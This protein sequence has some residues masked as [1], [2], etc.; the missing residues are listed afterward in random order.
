MARDVEFNY[1]ASDKTGPAADSVSKRAK[2][3]QDKIDKENDKAF[4]KFTK[5]ADAA[6]AAGGKLGLK[7]SEGLA[8]ALSEVGAMGPA[9]AGAV[10]GALPVIGASLA[11]AV[12][13]GSAGVGII[14]GALLASRDPRVKKAGADL[15]QRLLGQATQKA[16]VFVDPLLKGIDR[17]D[18]AFAKSGNDL[19][20]IFG[21][22]AKY[23]DP[24]VQGFTHLGGKVTHLVADLSEVAGPVINEFSTGIGNLGDA[25][26]E[27]LGSLKD[28]GVEAAMVVRQGFDV[29]NGSI[30][31]VGATINGLTEA[32][33]VLVKYGAFGRDAAVQY[34]VM[35]QAAAG[36]EAETSKVA[37]TMTKTEQVGGALG[38]AIRGVSEQVN[39][40]SS[41]NRTLYGSEVAVADALAN[42]T[43]KIQ[44]NGRGL[45]LNTEAGRENRGA[46]SSVAQ[47]LAN[48]YQ[49]YL[50]VNGAGAGAERVAYKA[51][52]SFTAL[53][54]QAGY[55]AG[56]AENLAD[57]LLG[58]PSRKTPVVN[59]TGNAIQRTGTVLERLAA[60]KSKTVSVNVAVRQSGDA[61]A[62]RK[63]S[64]PAFSASQHFAQVGEAGGAGGT[65]RTGGPAQVAVNQRLDVALDGRPFY[66]Y[67]TRRI[68]ESERRTAWRQK[69]G[70]R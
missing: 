61:A 4:K 37:E 27:S 43:K 5:N 50:K 11:A 10:A 20:R 64:A 31:V 44:D 32:Y 26:D 49:A 2:S 63:Q 38:D 45:K 62:L 1:T 3:T 35:E 46:L 55:S 34:R 6:A 21:S 53:A 7:L 51:R 42:A 25:L 29:L 48:N 15:G 65:Y 57:E 56:Q 40:L 68:A 22:T 59:L 66:S 39:G 67:T 41:A 18:T 14:G 28:N 9:L 58:I 60:I 36:A 33:G 23:V 13:G 24:L 54:R 30:R 69:V 70:T 12:I 52:D 47:A 19:D 16:S 17:V 8:G